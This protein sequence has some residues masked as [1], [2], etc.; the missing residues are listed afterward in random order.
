MATPLAAALVAE[1][2]RSVPLRFDRFVERCLYDPGHGFYTVAGGAAGRRADF[3][4]SPEVGPLFGAV[5]ARALDRW[6][7]AAGRPD[8][9]VVVDAGSGPGTLVRALL[10]AAPAC[11]AAWR[12]VAVERSPALREL[13]RDLAAK[14]VTSTD[15]LPAVAGGVVIANE[16]LDNVAFRLLERTTAGWADLAVTVADGALALTTIP[17]PADDAA[18]ATAL[19]P[20]AAVG[21]R[22]PL[23][24]DA[25]RWAADVL[26]AGP[27]HLV[28]VDYGRRA[29]S[30]FAASPWT[31]WVRTYRGHRRA[32]GPLAAPGEADITVEIAVDQLPTGAQWST[33][34]DF[35]R[36]HGI[37]ELV[38]EGRRSWAAGVSRPDLAALRGRSRVREAE[39]LLDPDG[40]GSWLVGH[41]GPNRPAVEDDGGPAPAGRGSVRP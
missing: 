9:F 11:S 12:L 3:I 4:T 1:L 34:A 30:A 41:W 35:L 19:V 39:A 31:E 40:L 10:A 15:E 6:W 21:A 28:V 36:A 14:G 37:D 33:Q 27:A 22:V 23:L 7:E 18:R 29:T 25:R 24:D 16:L 2:G 26:A 20:E 17:T 5:L 8:P 32:G 38:A 13:H